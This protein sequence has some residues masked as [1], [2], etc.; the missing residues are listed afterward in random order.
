MSLDEPSEIPLMSVLLGHG[1][2][3]ERAARATWQFDRDR[4]ML[5]IARHEYMSHRQK[6]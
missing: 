1:L 6:L 4:A 3:V 2:G 5:V